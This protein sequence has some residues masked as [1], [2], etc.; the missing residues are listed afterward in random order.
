MIR[1]VLLVALIQFVRRDHVRR[2]HV[3]DISQRAQQHSTLQK[4][5]VK[6]RPHCGEI[7]GIIRAQFDRS[8]RSDLPH[9]S[10]L[11]NAPATALSGTAIPPPPST[12]HSG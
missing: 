6:L 12:A 8:N 1:D 7:S 10:H 3:Y 2:Q 11:R 9:I 5:L 4:K